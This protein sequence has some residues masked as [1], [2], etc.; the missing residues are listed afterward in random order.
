MIKLENLSKNFG[1]LKAVDNITL[2]IPDGQICGYLGPNGAGKTTTVKL[3]TTMLKPDAGKA[4]ING[5][6]II[7]QSFEV[8]KS[9]GYVPESGKLYKSLTPYEYLMFTG[10]LYNVEQEILEK[11]INEFA[12]FF[13]FENQIHTRMISFSKGEK[14]RV[15][16]TSA[17]I[18]NPS[19]LFLDEPLSGLD[20]TTVLKFKELL[21]DMANKG[22]T[23]FYC[24]HIL[25]VVEKL[26]DRVVII[27]KGRIIGD[28]SV[29]ELENMTKQSSLEDVFRQLTDAG[30]VGSAVA[31][32]SKSINNQGN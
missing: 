18:H 30:D 29:N 28:G 12:K 20:A 2:Q 19:V 15:V 16:I 23:I 11:R 17:L 22:R 13:G 25:E 8:K 32:L 14:Q 7:T 3:L 1:S 21:R 24:S 10:S 5:F 27:D 4:W 6:D 26:C 31:A 9:I